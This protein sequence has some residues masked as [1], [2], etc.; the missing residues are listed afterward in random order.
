MTGVYGPKWLITL[1]HAVV[2][3]SIV[4]I[5]ELTFDKLSRSQKLIGLY[6][7]VFATVRCI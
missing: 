6:I 1:V 7:K 3:M 2:Q 5:I 4:Q